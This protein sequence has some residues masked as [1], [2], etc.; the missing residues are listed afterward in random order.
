MKKTLHSQFNIVIAGL[1]SA[2]LVQLP[3]QDCL[4]ETRDQLSEI[5]AEGLKNAYDIKSQQLKLE[6]SHNLLRNSYY[7]LLPTVSLSGGRTI[8]TTDTQPNGT[9]QT[10]TTNQS[11]AKATAS[12]TLFDNYQSIRNIQTS[13][14]TLDVQKKTS[15]KLLQQYV[16]T[17][18]DLYLQYQLLLSQKL[19]QEGLLEQNKWTEAESM[20]LVKAGA[21]TRLDSMDTEI[22]V[23]NAERD[24]L[25]LNN[26]ISAAEKNIF[27]I[28]N[29]DRYKQLPIID[30]LT[31]KPYYMKDFERRLPSIRSQAKRELEFVNPDLQISKGQLEVSLLNLKQTKLGYWPKTTVQIS[32]DMDFSDFVQTNAPGVDQVP[33]H[34]TTFSVQFS[35]QLWDW[36]ITPRTI[37]NAQKDFEISVNQYKQSLLQSSS[38]IENFL[39]QHDV[40]EKS[41][42]SSQ[43]VLDKAKAQVDYS[44]EMFEMGRITLL[45]M[46]QA[47]GRWRDARIALA[48]RL[49]A[50]YILAAKILYT[51]GYD[52][53]P[54]GSEVSWLKGG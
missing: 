45:E 54:E 13:E 37:D 38:D 41:I 26:N 25:E 43:L 39:A 3:T 32:H 17:L 42:Y 31:L 16:L 35:W 11:T 28:L 36:W 1:L 19:I 18:L 9:V 22:Q 23:V 46:Q 10:D 4:G 6:Q 7:N 49:E 33:L 52:L 24:L 20:A 53:Q 34:T 14:K 8:T 30:L 5:V 12:W 29:S 40:L 51:M 50:K 44:R 27:V 15:A 48:T 47:I 2:F 21:R